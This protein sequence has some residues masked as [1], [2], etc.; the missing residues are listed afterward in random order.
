M[1]KPN[2]PARQNK[3][4]SLLKEIGEA[5]LDML[6]GTVASK[7][8]WSIVLFAVGSVCVFSPIVG[9][10]NKPI[11]FYITGVICWIWALYLLIS[12]AIEINKE[13]NR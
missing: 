1:K 10:I 6:G 9:E 12:R 4:E 7:A 11:A 8:A 5:L 3:K 2:Q 13:N